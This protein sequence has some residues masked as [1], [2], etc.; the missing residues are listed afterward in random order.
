MRTSCMTLTNALARLDEERKVHHTKIFNRSI[1]RSIDDSI[2]SL[3]IKMVPICYS[4]TH[5]GS[6]SCFGHKEDVALLLANCILTLL[7]LSVSLHRQVLLAKDVTKTADLQQATNQVQ[8]LS[9]E[10]ERCVHIP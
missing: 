9:E 4:L 2:V 7:L 5:S 6:Q 8:R 3:Q 1:F 10:V